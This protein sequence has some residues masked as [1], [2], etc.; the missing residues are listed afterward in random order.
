METNLLSAG[1]PLHS[2]LIHPNGANGSLEVTA[3]REIH[4][5]RLRSPQLQMANS[6]NG[7]RSGRRFQAHIETSNPCEQGNPT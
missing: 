4:E 3:E 1:Q 6:H 5:A 7:N 2:Y